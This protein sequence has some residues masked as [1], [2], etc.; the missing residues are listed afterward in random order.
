MSVWPH[1]PPGGHT[2]H[3]PRT[4]QGVGQD[5]HDVGVGGEGV[6]E[7]SEGGVAHHHALELGLHLA[8]AQLELLDDV[9]DLLKAMDIAVRLPGSG[10]GRGRGQ[11]GDGGWA[12]QC[13]CCCIQQ[14]TLDRSGEEGR[15]RR[16]TL[17]VAWLITKNVA[18]SN[19]TTS[20]APHTSQNSSRCVSKRL[21]LGMR[22]YTMEDHAWRGGGGRGGGRGGGGRSQFATQESG[23][24]DPPSVVRAGVCVCV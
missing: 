20:S 10:R 15:D 11:Q 13:C 1:G 24:A 21:M 7:R 9:A 18:R 3:H 6:H 12:T 23:M 22:E 19:S 14:G 16:H 8:A 4:D 5:D 17:C 2:Q